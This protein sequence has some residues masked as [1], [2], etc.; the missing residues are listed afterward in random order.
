MQKRISLEEISR[1]TR[2][3]VDTLV[4]LEKEDHLNLPAEVF[5]KGFLRAYARTVGIDGEEAVRRYLSQRQ[6]R[7]SSFGYEADMRRSATGVRRGLFLFSVI[8]AV[9][10]AV[11]I[12]LFAFR[13]DIPYFKAVPGATGAGGKAV[14]PAIAPEPPAEDA[15]VISLRKNDDDSPS[16]PAREG[17]PAISPLP[18][19][20]DDE[21]KVDKRSKPLSLAIL[22]LEETWLKVIVDDQKPKVYKLKPEQRLALEADSGYNLLIGNATGLKIELNGKPYPVHGRHGQVVTVQIP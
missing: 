5:V 13:V 3:R 8:L 2:I 17:S 10:I 20:E 19:S 22:T 16:S 21:P 9:V 7:V 11:S 12:G 4:R 6:N 14:D 18:A 15:H 1:R